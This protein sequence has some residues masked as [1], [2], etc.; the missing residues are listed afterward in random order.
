LISYNPPDVA[1][2]DEFGDQTQIKKGKKRGVVILSLPLLR[3]YYSFAYPQLGSIL[4]ILFAEALQV[5]WTVGSW[6]QTKKKVPKRALTPLTP[7][8]SMSLGRSQQVETT[9]KDV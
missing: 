2:A 5:F 4:L 6:L 3:L 9:E 1:L 7:P 8:S